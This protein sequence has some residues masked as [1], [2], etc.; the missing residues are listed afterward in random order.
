MD[1][2]QK[3]KIV[4]WAQAAISTCGPMRVEDVLGSFTV[5]FTG[6]PSS[7]ILEGGGLTQ[8]SVE[9]EGHF[10]TLLAA[11]MYERGRALM[12]AADGLMRKSKTVKE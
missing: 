7:I 8:V 9:T 10:Q 4:G 3:D 6:E 1:K 5:T 12:L 11:L 2:Q